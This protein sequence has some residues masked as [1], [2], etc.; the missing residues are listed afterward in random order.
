MKDLYSINSH[1][2]SGILS[3]MSDEELKAAFDI[4]QAFFALCDVN[5][6]SLY[7][8]LFDLLEV[9]FIEEIVRRFLQK[10]A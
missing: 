10:I 3:S 1:W 5:N 2:F 7:Y 9:S 4:L 6:V 8:E